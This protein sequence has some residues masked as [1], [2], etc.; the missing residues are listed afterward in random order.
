FG[1]VFGT[2]FTVIGTILG[3]LTVYELVKKFGRPLVHFFISEEKIKKFSVLEDEKRLAFWVFVLFLIPGIPKDLLTYIVP[4]TKLPGKQFLLLS[5]LARF[6]ALAASVIMGNNFMKGNYWHCVVIA[7]IVI[8]I[9]IFG[10]SI[11][12]KILNKK[13]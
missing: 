5:A 10:F 8:V 2:I 12:N 11:K 9:T 6:P 3:T 13:E 4:L 7:C 1:G